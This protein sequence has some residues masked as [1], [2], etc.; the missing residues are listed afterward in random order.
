[1]GP[2]N[3]EGVAMRL[4]R[5]VV[6]VTGGGTGIGEGIARRFATEGARVAIT[7]R[8]KD[9]LED[10]VS[11]IQRA[12]GEALALPGSVTNEGDVRQAVQ[13]TLGTFGRIDVLVNNAG[14]LFHA[15]WLH[16]TTDAVWNDT[17]DVFLT[18]AFRFSRAVIPQ[19]LTQRGGSILNISTVSA[20][21]AM[22]GFPAHAYAAAKAGVNML[23][24][25]IAI[26][27]A[28]QGIRCNAVCPAGVDTPGVA[29]LTSDPSQR[30][31]FDRLH[32]VGRI[33]KPDE[34]AAA[35]V[36]FASDESRW[37]TG[38]ILAVDGGVSAQ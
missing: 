5:K 20:L 9:R 21:K 31:A 8:R 25:T 33:G 12:G 14:N 27:Y 22:P 7:G 37:T 29:G 26:Q 17:L 16:E 36:Y 10:V 3:V 18:G 24:K 6:V 15:G 11:A 32:P 4:A 1:L 28:E 34:I 35:A 38:S 23:T 19:M 13:A 2:K 30:V